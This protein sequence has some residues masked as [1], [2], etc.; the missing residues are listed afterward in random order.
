MNQRQLDK[1]Q[2]I[3]A[4]PQRKSAKK[5]NKTQAEE[6]VFDKAEQAEQIENAIAMLK[7][8]IEELEEKAKDASRDEKS[9]LEDQIEHKKENLI[10][11]QESSVDD[12]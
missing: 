7:D 3:L 5:K 2:K 1:E 10:S 4:A 11:I 8:D 12:E 6:M 9:R